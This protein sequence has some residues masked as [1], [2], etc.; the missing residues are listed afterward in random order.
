[1]LLKKCLFYGLML[2][3]LYTLA[4]NIFMTDTLRIP[5][6]VIFC[7]L[8]FF[9][10]KP[11][12]DFGYT[13]ELIIFLIGVFL[14]QVVGMNNYITFFAILLTIIPCSLYFNY[15]VGANKSR[16]Y[17]S[18]LMFFFLLMCSMII[19][20]LDHSM[21]GIIDPIRSMLLGEPVKQSPA[22]LAVTQFNFG[23]QVVAIT[24]FAFIASCTTGQYLIVRALVL[25]ACIVCIY[26]GM[27]RSA[28][29]SFGAGVTLFLF[30]YYRYRAVF[31]VA[32]TVIICF[33]LYTYVLKDNTDDKNNILSKNQAKEAND[34]NRADMAAENLKIFADYPFGLIFYGKTW[35]DVTYRNPLFTFGLSSHNAYLMF[36]TLLGPFLGLGLL[37]AIYYKTVRLFWQTI[38]NVKHKGSAIYV[39]I[40]FT[41]IAISLNA[42]SHNGWLMSVDGPTIFIYFAVLHYNRLKDP[43]KQTEPVQEELAVA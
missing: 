18:I 7:M 38:K 39:A 19:M 13:K 17:A 14:Y 1:M 6:P 31:L 25:A 9:V 35:N 32:A 28:F 37:W 29:I 8:L 34:F 36:I 21:A 5:A 23:Y 27:N 40:F 15:F 10:Q 11:L 42:L 20:V 3:Y 4:F 33:G 30:I 43:V 16:Y 41:F 26:L 22:G 12:L 24:T 2:F